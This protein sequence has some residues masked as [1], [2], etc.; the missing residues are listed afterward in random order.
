MVELIAYTSRQPEFALTEEDMSKIKDAQLKAK[1]LAFL[2][3]SP[4]TRGMDLTVEC[5]AES[6]KV[7]VRG[8]PPAVGASVWQKDI[9][10]VISQVKGVSSVEFV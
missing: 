8:A 9:Q 7:K 5:H 3:R 2:A 1:V 4:R 6:G 10:E